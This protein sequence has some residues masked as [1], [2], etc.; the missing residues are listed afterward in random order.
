MNSYIVIALF[1]IFTVSYVIISYHLF[2]KKINSPFSNIKLKESFNFLNKELISPLMSIEKLYEKYRSLPPRKF[3]FSKMEIDNGK[4]KH[5][6]SFI[7]SVIELASKLIITVGI[8]V[9]TLTASIQVAVLSFAQNNTS[10][11]EIDQLGWLT[12]ITNSH[13]GLIYTLNSSNSFITVCGILF[14]FSMLI[15]LLTNLKKD[16]FNRH[17]LVIQ[18]IEKEK[19]K[20]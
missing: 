18:E 10:L 1:A 11:K 15:L 8:A 16:E 4:L 20:N 17:S 3:I 9:I 5:D 13:K 6:D 12:N 19:N 14:I 2:I 7:N